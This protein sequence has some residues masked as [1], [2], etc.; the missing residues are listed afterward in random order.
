MILM[1]MFGAVSCVMLLLVVLI[2]PVQAENENIPQWIKQVALLWGSGQIS[3]DEFLSALQYLIR[4]GILVVPEPEIVSTF[5]SSEPLP[6]N[7]HPDSKQGKMTRIVDGDT[8]HID[9]DVYRLSLI[10]TPER[11]ED[12]YREATDA[13]KQLCPIDSK[14]YYDD[15][16]IQGSD[17]YGRYLGVIWCSGNDYSVTAGE[18]LANNGYL[19]KF[20]TNYCD[21]TEA[22][23]EKWAEE[24]GNYFYYRICN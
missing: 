13:L 17:R 10:D 22:S 23:T 9:E 4:M 8:V 15:D 12:G 21:N 20:Y 18:Y 16:S 19:K 24:T 2:I 6:A 7:V 3:D 5:V 11:G 14:V 1:I